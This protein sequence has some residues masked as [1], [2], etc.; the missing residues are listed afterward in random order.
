VGDSSPDIPT[1]TKKILNTKNPIVVWGSG[2]QRR[3]YI[4]ALDCAR[5]MLQLVENGY[6]E[7]PVNIGREETVSVKNLVH[8][9]AAIGGLKPEIVF[10]RSKPEGRFIKSAD[11]KL[12]I[13]AL[14][15]DFTWKIDLHEGLQRMV[16]W[17]G[18]TFSDSALLATGP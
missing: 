15:D 11:S 12:L 17:Y 2:N 7:R 16:N 13:A 1:L 14:G 3:N 8:R 9:I 5:A 10:D 6:F 4:H 18:R